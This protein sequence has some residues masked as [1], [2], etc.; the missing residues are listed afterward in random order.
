MSSTRPGPRAPV[1][2]EIHN[3]T[4][5]YAHVA[6][7]VTN[8]P[9]KDGWL[10]RMHA[11]IRLAAWPSSAVVGGGGKEGSGLWHQIF[12]IHSLLIITS[13][14]FSGTEIRKLR[15]GFGPLDDQVCSP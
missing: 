10:T 3:L 7:Q 15:M 5:H 6:Q 11:Y 12:N 2:L 4:R 9:T 1:A 13:L 14:S 8:N